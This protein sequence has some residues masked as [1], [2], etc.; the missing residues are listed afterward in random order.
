MLT[1]R[2][3]SP[4]YIYEVLSVHLLLDW[5]WVRS[6]HRLQLHLLVGRAFEQ[7]VG[8]VARLQH[9]NDEQGA[10]ERVDVDFT[11]LALLG[12]AYVEEEGGPAQDI[13][14]PLGEIIVLLGLDLHRVQGQVRLHSDVPR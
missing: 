5:C 14:L 10:Q 11:C 3:T 12:A 2:Q 4:V 1:C 8:D 9:L 7:L 6:L 13:D